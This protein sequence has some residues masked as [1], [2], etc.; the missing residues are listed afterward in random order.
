MFTIPPPSLTEIHSPS[1]KK[2]LILVQ[3]GSFFFQEKI[4]K[5]LKY[6]LLLS[7]M[8]EIGRVIIKNLIYFY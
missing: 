4:S 7:S 3:T 2:N 5:C 8:D 1:I 6:T